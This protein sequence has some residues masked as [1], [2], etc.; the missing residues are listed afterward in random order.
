MNYDIKTSTGLPTVTVASNRMQMRWMRTSALPEMWNVWCSFVTVYLGS[1]ITYRHNDEFLKSW[2]V[3][4]CADSEHRTVPILREVILFHTESFSVPNW[5]LEVFQ[6]ERL[7]RSTWTVP[8]YLSS[9]LPLTD[10]NSQAAIYETTSISLIEKPTAS[11]I[12]AE[13]HMKTKILGV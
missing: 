2:L 8:W 3:G 9:S 6:L 11:I 4:L 7:E 12:V 10:W 5:F 13:F 1:R